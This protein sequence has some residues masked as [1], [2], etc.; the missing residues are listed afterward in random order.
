[1]RIIKNHG[2]VLFLSS[3]NPSD[4]A[5]RLLYNCYQGRTKVWRD[6]PKAHTEGNKK[7]YISHIFI[8]K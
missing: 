1:M 5:L 2:Y 7:K 8:K 4:M 6:L 3:L